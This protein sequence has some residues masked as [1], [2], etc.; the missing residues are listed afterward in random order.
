MS[1]PSSSFR[2]TADVPELGTIPKMDSLSYFPLLIPSPP[3]L[4]LIACHFTSENGT[5]CIRCVTSIADTRQEEGTSYETQERGKSLK[6]SLLS[7]PQ[8]LTRSVSS[9]PCQIFAADLTF[10]SL[11]SRLKSHFHPF[12]VSS[13]QTVVIF[14]IGNEV[15]QQC[16]IP[17]YTSILTCAPSFSSSSW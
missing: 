15:H 7:S 1:L 12:T 10:S 9:P 16:G 8:D 4:H 6:P 13:S 5:Q 17:L 11:S 14:S 3:R 2:A